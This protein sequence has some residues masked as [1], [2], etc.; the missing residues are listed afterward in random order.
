MF[1]D[2]CVDFINYSELYEWKYENI[3]SKYLS[4]LNYY[5]RDYAVP[6]DA[7]VSRR[8][9]HLFSELVRVEMINTVAR[10]NEVLKSARY[11]AS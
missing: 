3:V 4:T 11:C 9:L 8:D 5:A 10:Q 1:Y 6:V 2:K 7:K